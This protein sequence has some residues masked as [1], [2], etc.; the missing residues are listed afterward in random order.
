[1]I[2]IQGNIWDYF[3]EDGS[4]LVIPTNG[5]VKKNG[6]CVM[7]AGL[8]LQCANRYPTIPKRLG[9]A[10]KTGGNT[11]HILTVEGN[12]RIYSFPVKHNWWERADIKLIIQSAKSLAELM[13]GTIYLPRVGCGNGGLKWPDVHKEI[14]EILADDRFIVVNLET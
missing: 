2:E 5:L 12:K 3:K 6:K 13:S 4:R 1:M 14:K 9:T 8:A 11:I 10:I 7:G